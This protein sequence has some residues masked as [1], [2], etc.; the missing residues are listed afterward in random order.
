MRK[1]RLMSLMTPG[2]F[3]DLL[4]SLYIQYDIKCLRRGT[5]VYAHV[6]KQLIKLCRYGPIPAANSSCHGGVLEALV[7]C[8][9]VFS[10]Q[11]K[12]TVAGSIFLSRLSLW[13]PAVRFSS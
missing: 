7:M 11:G 5:A 6:M 2:L 8:S 12:G 13:E 3:V 4:T 10:E 1:T 9:L